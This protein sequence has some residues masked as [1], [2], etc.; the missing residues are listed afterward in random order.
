MEWKC[1][2]KYVF[3]NGWKTISVPSQMLRCAKPYHYRT[4]CHCP[5]MSEHADALKNHWLE[6]KSKVFGGNIQ[7]WTTSEDMS[8]ALWV[9]SQRSAKAGEDCSNLCLTAMMWCLVFFI[10]FN[11][12]LL[13]LH[14]VPL[15]QRQFIL[16]HSKR[17]NVPSRGRGLRTAIIDLWHPDEATWRE[18]WG[19]LKNC[20]IWSGLSFVSSGYS[21]S[22]IN[23]WK[24]LGLRQAKGSTQGC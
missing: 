19:L 17:C 7:L 13:H 2:R 3:G 15:G 16:F 10:L 14:K 6:V 22:Y 23:N 21:R 20:W 4:F 5:K 12:M 1:G 9:D 18:T 24:W 8:A 11:T